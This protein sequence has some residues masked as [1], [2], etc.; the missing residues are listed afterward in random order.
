MNEGIK[1]VNAQFTSGTRKKAAAWVLPEE[2]PIAI[3]ID[4]ETEKGETYAVM[5]ATPLDLIDFAYGFCISEGLVKAADAIITIQQ[6]PVK[7]GIE[8]HVKLSDQ[9]YDRFQIIERRRRLAGASGC[10]VCG[11]T[12]LSHIVEELPKINSSLTIPIAAVQKAKAQ[13]RDHTP[14]NQSSFSVHAAA[15]ANKD[16]DI[17]L[18]REDVGRHNAL[19]KLCGALTQQDIDISQGFVLLTSRFAY[20]LAQKCIKF[21]V[22]IVVSISAP[23]TMA[24]NMAKKANMTFAAFDGESDLMVF[25]SADRLV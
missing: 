14:L 7:D 1:S 11:L 22:P 24:V 17:L 9:A 5:L 6:K 18:V 8:L 13:L 23:T 16:G 15:F 12:S 3:C 4:G 21:G 10:G 25:S 20:E 2:C 19:D